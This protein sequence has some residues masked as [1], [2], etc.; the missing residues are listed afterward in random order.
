MPNIRVLHVCVCVCVCVIVLHPISIVS[1]NLDLI[2]IL[3][4]AAFKK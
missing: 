3:I 2:G 4:M 1:Y